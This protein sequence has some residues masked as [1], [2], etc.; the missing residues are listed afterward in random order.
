M[1]YL[2]LKTFCF[3]VFLMPYLAFSDINYKSLQ[4]PKGF[5]VKLFA[6]DITAPR[7]MA[8]GNNFIF[9]GGIK[10]DIYAIDKNNTKNNK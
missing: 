7:Q 2:N 3:L 1:K 8:E 6:S 4:T 10:G 5:S 9:V